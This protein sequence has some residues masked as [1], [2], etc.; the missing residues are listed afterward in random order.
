[1]NCLVT[2]IQRRVDNKDIPNGIYDGFWGGYGIVFNIGFQY[3]A[4]Q[5]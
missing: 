2:D 1:M 3:F 4:G 5:F